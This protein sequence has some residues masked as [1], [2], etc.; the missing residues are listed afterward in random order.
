MSSGQ[1]TLSNWSPPSGLGY[2]LLVADYEGDD[3]YVPMW[4]VIPVDVVLRLPETGTNIGASLGLAA[5]LLLA[6]AVLVA[7]SRRRR[8]VRPA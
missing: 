4:S 1:V 6:G 8:S 3:V 2:Y 5:T 7:G